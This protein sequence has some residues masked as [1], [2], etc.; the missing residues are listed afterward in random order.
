MTFAL[1]SSTFSGSPFFKRGS[2][3][4]PSVGIKDTE[5]VFG[6]I[7]AESLVEPVAARTRPQLEKDEK[8]DPEI[9]G[10]AHLASSPYKAV[11]TSAEVEIL[12]AT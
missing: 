7:G 6:V 3:E 2:I 5:T 9:V 4:L 12:D 11:F 10:F 8:G 1:S